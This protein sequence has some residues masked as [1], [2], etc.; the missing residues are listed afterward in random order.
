MDPAPY[1]NPLTLEQWE[2][3]RYAINHLIVAVGFN[4]TGA[5]S[6]VLAHALIPSLVM[7]HDAPSDISVFRRPLYVIAVLSIAFGVFTIVRA[8]L[9]AIPVAFDMF[10]RILI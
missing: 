1:A 9:I 8:A 6:L 7:T 10:P 5:L 2:L 3:T 4:V